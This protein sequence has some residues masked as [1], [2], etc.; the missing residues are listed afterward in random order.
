MLGNI[1]LHNQVCGRRACLPHCVH[2]LR[3]DEEKL[4]SPGHALCLVCKKG[5]PP[6][7]G[8]VLATHPEVTNS[9]Q[10]LPS[11]TASN[12][13]QASL[14]WFAASSTV[15]RQAGKCCRMLPW[16]PFWEIP[17]LQTLYGS[18]KS[19]T[20]VI[21]WCAEFVGSSCLRMN[22]CQIFRVFYVDAVVWEINFNI[23]FWL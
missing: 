19:V 4:E 17:L 5:R 15:M 9:S 20:M 11:A 21:H 7:R 10:I 16:K 1:Y 8:N 13:D 22:G 6:G 2:F 14:L 3:W 18:P 23:L 12:Y